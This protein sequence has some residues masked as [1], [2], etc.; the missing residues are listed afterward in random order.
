MLTFFVVVVLRMLLYMHVLHACVS[1]PQLHLG[2][3]KTVC[4]WAYMYAPSGEGGR[5]GVEIL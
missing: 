4:T 2:T 5:G 1:C 3:S